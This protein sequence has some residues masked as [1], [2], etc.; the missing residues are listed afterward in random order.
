[1]NSDRFRRE[2]RNEAGRALDD[3]RRGDGRPGAARGPMHQGGG[4]GEY[5]YRDEDS[6]QGRLP[7]RTGFDPIGSYDLRP[8]FGRPGDVGRGLFVGKG[9]KGYQ[10]SDERILED[11]SDALARNGELDA[12]EI[13]VQVSAGEVTLDGTVPD[14]S[15]KRLAEDLV[16]D[17]LGVKHVHNR[18]RVA[19]VSGGERRTL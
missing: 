7:A 18:L 5:N 16:E 9:P 3:G 2:L 19:A 17:L 1:M 13:V 4:Y 15:S 6:P 10:R 11:V 12:S 8:S 14:R